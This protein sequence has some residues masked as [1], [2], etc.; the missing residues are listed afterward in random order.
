MRNMRFFSIV[1]VAIV[2]IW[3]GGCN[4]NPARPTEPGGGNGNV[5][6]P[7]IL[8]I[9]GEVYASP[10]GV[11]VYTM[12]GEVLFPDGCISVEVR[13]IDPGRSSEIFDGLDVAIKMVV[14][15]CRDMPNIDGNG[16]TPI[17]DTVADGPDGKLIHSDWLSGSG[18][19]LQPGQSEEFTRSSKVY[20]AARPHPLTKGLR[21]RWRIN[22]GSGEWLRLSPDPL[23]EPAYIVIPLGWTYRSSV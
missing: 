10:V 19:S 12:G 16:I 6:P 20:A 2:C 1:A 21:V 5:L 8:P 22:N 4:I 11:R 13:S 3:V 18:N 15:A 7:T 17:F 9:G 23:E 14:S